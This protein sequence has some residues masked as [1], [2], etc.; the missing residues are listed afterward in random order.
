MQTGNQ[1]DA[2]SIDWKPLPAP[3]GSPSPHIGMSILEVDEK[4]HIVDVLFKF[5]ANEKI[6]MHRHTSA[7][8]TLVLQGE[9]RI[10][11]PSGALK[12]IRPTGTYRAGKADDE[13]HTEGGGDEDVIILFSLRPYDEHAPIYEVL[14]DNLETVGTMNFAALRD[15]YASGAA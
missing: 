3:D 7:F 8:N 5:A 12:E 2:S 10:Y 4:A 14:D 13:P 11:E 6:V 9:H 1:F 15:L